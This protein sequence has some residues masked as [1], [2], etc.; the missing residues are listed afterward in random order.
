MQRTIAL[1][2]LKLQLPV[3]MPEKEKRFVFLRRKF[4]HEKQI[5]KTFSSSYDSIEINDINPDFPM[6]K[7][8]NKGYYGIVPWTL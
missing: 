5:C 4:I 7:V 2:L 6:I 3:Q 1:Q 8:M